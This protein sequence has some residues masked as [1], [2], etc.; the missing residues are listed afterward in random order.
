M[1]E[2]CLIVKKYLNDGSKAQ[3][4]KEVVRHTRAFNVA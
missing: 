4:S 1:R 3:K 2:A